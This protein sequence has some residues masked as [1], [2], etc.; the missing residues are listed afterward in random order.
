MQQTQTPT[1]NT[2]SSHEIPSYLADT[3]TW[4]YLNPK[5]V[6]LLDRD[7][8]VSA[9]LWGNGGRLMRAVVKEF[10]SG[11]HVLQSACVYG[12]ITADLVR[13]LGPQGS[14]QVVDVAPVQID[15]L[16]RK[17]PH[18]PTLATH[19][20]DLAAPGSLDE[21]PMYDGVCCVFL[22]HEVPED[23]RVQIVQNLLEKVRPGGKIVFLDYHKTVWWHP[24]RPAMGF[25]FRTLEPY[26]LSLT[27]QNI[28]TLC[29]ETAAEFTWNK[30]TL[31][32]GLYQI[33]VGIRSST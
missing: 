4:A 32:G 27:K 30:R 5:S 6:R 14:L 15:N 2:T 29:P 18:C 13:K 7:W 3:Y 25:I 22:L 23:A 20:A 19:I 16:R 11:E 12:H 28:E 31:F 10:S 9:I 21:F 1:T 24:L 17:L 8:I 33:V 26:A